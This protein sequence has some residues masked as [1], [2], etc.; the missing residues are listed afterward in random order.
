VLPE[1][2]HIN[3]ERVNVLEQPDALRDRG[4]RRVPVLIHGE[5]VLTG[6]F[7]TRRSIRRFLSALPVSD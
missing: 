6:L 2:P 1:F 4:I 3:I 5:R 7:L